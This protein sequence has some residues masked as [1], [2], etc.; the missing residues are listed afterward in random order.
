MDTVDELMKDEDYEAAKEYPTV[1]MPLIADVLQRYQEHLPYA[2][3]YKPLCHTH[4]HTSPTNPVLV[5]RDCWVDGESFS[6]ANTGRRS[7]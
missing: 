3:S 5:C 4:W 7:K 2:V 1:V 6:R